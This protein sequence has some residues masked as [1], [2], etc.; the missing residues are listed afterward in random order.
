[1][2]LSN[3]KIKIS[4]SPILLLLTLLLTCT[5]PLMIQAAGSS[6]DDDSNSQKSRNYQEAVSYIKKSDY[7]SAIPLLRRELKRNSRDADAHNYMGY[8]LRK[9]NDLKNSAVHYAKALEINPKHLGALEYQG[10][11]FLT[12]GNLDLAKANLQKLDKLCWLGCD[13]YEDLRASIEDYQQG[14]KS[15][16]Y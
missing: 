6:D 8:A 9:S 14:K 4:I 3:T 2:A 12:I 1:M 15:S 7:S 10:E 13:E 11:L 5:S 16:R